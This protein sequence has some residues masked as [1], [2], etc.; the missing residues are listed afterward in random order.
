MFNKNLFL[1]A[2]IVT[3]CCGYEFYIHREYTYCAEDLYKTEKLF[4]KGKYLEALLDDDNDTHGFLGLV[5]KYLNKK[6]NNKVMLYVGLCLKEIEYYE[7]ALQ[8]LLPLELEYIADK[9]TTYKLL[10]LIGDLCV[11]LRKCSDA[12]R[13]YNEAINYGYYCDSDKLVYLFKLI[14]LYK[15]L[16]LYLKAYKLI[17]DFISKHPKTQRCKDLVD[18]KRKIEI[19]INAVKQNNIID[20]I[21]TYN[22]GNVTDGGTAVKADG[23]TA[24]KADGGTAVKADG[25]TAVKADGSAS[26]EQDDT[27]KK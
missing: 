5:G 12:E 25:G 8:Y 26:I 19:V 6:N 11:Q 23:G 17:N 3:T 21:K 7:A 16:K 9:V 13:Y 27:A 2:C 18:E 22:G 14:R 10:G 1:M 4:D 15:D 24:V 20:D